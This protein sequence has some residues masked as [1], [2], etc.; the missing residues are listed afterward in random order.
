MDLRFVVNTIAPYLLTQKLLP[1]LRA[2]GR[3]VN[4]SSAAQASVNLAALSGD[5]R[6][7]DDMEAYAQSKLAITMWS[8]DMAEALNEGPVVIAVNPGSLLASKMVREG[9]GVPGKD[10]SIGA[11]VLVRA[12][13]SKEFTD[14][15]GKYFDNDEG[16]FSDPH[17]D[18][19]DPS[20][21]SDVV[22]AIEALL[23]KTN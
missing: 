2:S 3:I 5:V 23:A 15:S 20:K 22:Q 21:C 6:L 4:V 8:R 9:F 14:A 10:L 18:V 7:G 19:L 1:L 16:R 13:L 11:K 12:T 17:P